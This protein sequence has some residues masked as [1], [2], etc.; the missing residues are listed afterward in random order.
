[1]GQVELSDEKQ[2]HLASGYQAAIK[3]IDRLFDGQMRL[4]VSTEVPVKDL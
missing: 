4:D 3:E 2:R 1:L